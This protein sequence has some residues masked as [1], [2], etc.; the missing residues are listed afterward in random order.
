MA[1]QHESP[2]I[3]DRSI[4]VGLAGSKRPLEEGTANPSAGSEV[5]LALGPL[6]AATKKTKLEQSPTQEGLDFAES[7]S[8]SD[9]FFT[10]EFLLQDSL[11]LQKFPFNSDRTNP[12]AVSMSSSLNGEPSVS[13]KLPPILFGTEQDTETS[14]DDGRDDMILPSSQPFSQWMDLTLTAEDPSIASLYSQDNPWEVPKGVGDGESNQDK[15]VDIHHASPTCATAQQ[16]SYFLPPSQGSFVMATASN[17]R[18]LYFPK[19]PSVLRQP[20]GQVLADARRTTNELLQSKKG[21][22]SRSMDHIMD[23]LEQ[24]RLSTALLEPSCS[25]V[26]QPLGDKVTNPATT[27]NSDHAMWVDTYQPRYFSDLVSDEKVNREALLWIKQ[28]DYCV[29]GRKNPNLDNQRVFFRSKARYNNTSSRQDSAAKESE[30]SKPPPNAASGGEGT[31]AVG[32]KDPYQRPYRRILLLAG[33]P[34]LGKT[35]LAHIIARQAGY[36]TMEINASDDRTGTQVYQKLVSITQTH[37]VRASGKPTALIIDEVDGVIGGKDNRGSSGRDFISLLVDM[38]NAEATPRFPSDHESGTPGGIMSTDDRKRKTRTGPPPLMRPIIC[39]CNDLYA[40][41]LRNLRAVAQV[42]HLRPPPAAVLA[43]RLQSICQAEAVYVDLSTLVSLCDRAESDLRSCLH[44][45]QFLRRQLGPQCHL[46]WE[47]MQ[48]A[49]VGVKDSQRSLFQIWERIFIPPDV[50]SLIRKGLPVRA[51]TPG[52]LVSQRSRTSLAQHTYMQQLTGDIEACHEY[53]K[54]LM[55]CFENYPR[56]R[57][58]DTYF[59][60]IV[61]FGD[62]LGF[63]DRLNTLVYQ[64]HGGGSEGKGALYQYMAYPLLY[65]HVAFANPFARTLEFAYPRMEYEMTVRRKTCEQTL[66]S[67][68]GGIRMVAVRSQWTATRAARDLIPW[69]V[70]IL[71]TPITATN[72]QLLKH[73]EKLGLGR[74]VEVMASFGIT[75]RQERDEHG[76]FQYHL[77]PS[78]ETTLVSDRPHATVWVELLKPGGPDHAKSTTSD[79]TIRRT[80]LLPIKYATRQLIAQEVEKENIRRRE[81]LLQNKTPLPTTKSSTRSLSP[82]SAEKKL[83]PHPA[84]A[85]TIPPLIPPLLPPTRAVVKDFFGRPIPST[86]DPVTEASCSSTHVASSALRRARS[87]RDSTSNSPSMQEKSFG[88]VWY[89]YNEG[90]SNAV[91]RPVKMSEF[92]L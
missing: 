16:P 40:P 67:L 69:L 25:D 77:Q 30:D 76:Q 14:Q 1:A 23:E 78:L 4:T 73:E 64:N 51:T 86:A 44:T 34:G 55:G 2:G 92:M 50:R 18:R 49:P 91:R 33:P 26:D 28:W 9:L 63:Y 89:Q 37:S 60:K 61:Q 29:F 43:R 90:F 53:D 13:L 19:R 21:L 85:T 10:S 75:Y 39:I 36:T 62:W 15:Q 31:L 79:T 65:S 88:V 24:E 70:R 12:S 87:F 22:I 6:Q 52:T 81:Q 11:L 7:R 59:H 27:G 84:Q 57:F 54:L 45:L 8:E 72:F 48:Q 46:K 56:L 58:H 68:I 66:G 82:A 71:A 47:H 38:A 83:E 80:T 32:P 5:Q 3:N 35:T 17:G 42:Y 74:L 20:L 41:A